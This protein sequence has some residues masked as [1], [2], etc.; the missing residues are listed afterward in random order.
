MFPALTQSLRNLWDESDHFSGVT[1][2]VWVPAFD[3][4]RGCKPNR[5]NRL[6]LR[7]WQRD[8]CQK[9][10]GG[11]QR[12]RCIFRMPETYVMRTVRKSEGEEAEELSLR[13]IEMMRS[14]G[15]SSKK[16]L[17]TVWFWFFFPNLGFLLRCVIGERWRRLNLVGLGCNRWEW[18][19]G[20]NLEKED[21][22]HL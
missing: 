2:K 8:C 19:E 21:E 9:L 10:V 3:K 20:R 16:L 18:R 7:Y 17:L 12:R 6:H 14:S 5:F 13:R 15:K 1:A 11:D 22:R 4:T